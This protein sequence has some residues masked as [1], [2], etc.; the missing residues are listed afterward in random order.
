MPDPSC[1]GRRGREQGTTRPPAGRGILTAAIARSPPH[2]VGARDPLPTTARSSRS[3]LV[4]GGARRSVSNSA[5]IY[6]SRPNP[7][8]RARP[9]MSWLAH[10][11]ARTSSPRAS[12]LRNSRVGVEEPFDQTLSP[13]RG[14]RR[15]SC[16]PVAGAPTD[17]RAVPLSARRGCGRSARTACRPPRRS[18]ARNT[19]VWRAPAQTLE[20]R[21]GLVRASLPSPQLVVPAYGIQRVVACGCERPF[22]RSC[23]SASVAFAHCRAAARRMFRP[24]PRA[25]GCQ[26]HDACS[27]SEPSAPPLIEAARAHA[28]SGDGRASSG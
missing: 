14:G 9:E 12:H 23:H 24:R 7:P 4:S 27:W 2:G 22:R 28:G 16:R 21:H 20:E 17:V 11:S 5:A 3:A 10:R 1:C 19:L 15:F 8:A 18:R 26:S 13:G 25:A 6:Q